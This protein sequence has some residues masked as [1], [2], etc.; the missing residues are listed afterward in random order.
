MKKAASDTSSIARS[1]SSVSG[2]VMISRLLGLVREQAFAYLFGAG[3]AFDAFV[4]AFRIPNMLR[5]LFGEGALSTAFVTVFTEV[6]EGGDR[7]RVRRLAGNVVVFFSLLVGAICLAGIL[8]A[9]SLVRLMVEQGFESDPERMGLAVDL[10][11]IMFPFLLFVSIAS[12]F[13]GILNTLGRFF[14]P[15]LASSF[16]NVGSLTVG[17]GLALLFPRLGYPAIA[18]MA[19]GTLA[20]GFLQMAG[21]LPS[22]H[23]AGFRFSFNLNLRDP[24]LVRI[25]RLMLP[26]VAGLSAL[27]LNVFINNFFASS[28]AVGALSWLN[29]AFRLFQFPVGVFGV[30]L[31][32]AATPVMARHA[33]RS[34]MAA[35]RETYVSSLVMA[36][37][38]SLPAAAGLAVL[39][40]PV[41]RVVFEYGR[42]SLRATAMTAAALRAYLVG[43]AAY[44]AVKVTV[45][46]F[47]SLDET[48]WPVAGSFIA[49]A[50]NLG[51][52][53]STIASLGH[54]AMA[55]G[56][57][58]GM[59]ANFL[60]LFIVVYR[61][62]GGF[63][64]AYLASG[65]A[66]VA[67]ATLAMTL[68]TAAGARLVHRLAPGRPVEILFLLLLIA[69]AAAVYGLFLH[70]LRLREFAVIVGRL[71]QRLAG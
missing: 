61:R 35:L 39:A 36:L 57:S 11:R 30:A 29:Y 50:V 64:L 5:D 37:A 44:A 20:G 25:L 3:P 8:G 55:L 14:I 24:G 56:I 65:A 13:M 46:V 34:D 45:P 15:A 68:L 12:V 17:V 21:Q 59:S 7:E 4:V 47:Y 54:R 10:T 71:R 23:R 40:E 22:I 66:R 67:G 48:R 51:V 41:C 2:A 16:F 38:L 18:G 63:S 6:R 69:A 26:A 53:L 52:V 27:Q 1:A 43:L 62:L 60:F 49:V 31:A 58:L 70:L 32:V 42:F 33:A 19:C 9:D 28:L